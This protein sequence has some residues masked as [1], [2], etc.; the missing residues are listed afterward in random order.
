MWHR[1]LQVLLVVFFLPS[2][3]SDT[4]R[5][6]KQLAL[7]DMQIAVALLEITLTAASVHMKIYRELALHQITLVL[8]TSGQCLVCKPQLLRILCLLSGSINTMGW[9]DTT[10]AVRGQIELSACDFGYRLLLSCSIGPSLSLCK[11]LGLLQ[12]HFCCLPVSA[13]QCIMHS[14]ATQC[15]PR[16][17]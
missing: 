13:I 16:T 17:S 5:A 11:R 15:L 2:T 9:H 10:L 4:V 3:G 8:Y 7:C 14:L 6:H 12:T 1:P